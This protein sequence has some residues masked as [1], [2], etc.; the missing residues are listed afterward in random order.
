MKVETVV[1]ATGLVS[2]SYASSSSLHP[3]CAL[4]FV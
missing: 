1:V 4:K 2:S 3:V